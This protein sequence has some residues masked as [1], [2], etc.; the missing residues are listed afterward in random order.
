MTSPQQTKAQLLAQLEVLRQRVAELEAADSER[1]QAEAALQVSETRYRRLFETA[2]DGILILE[3][4]T[5]Q[6]TDVNPFLQEMLG[7]A[8]EE[9]LGKQLWEIGPFKDALASQV[10]FAELQSKGYIRYE[11]L[12]LERSDGRH[13][14]VE[15]VSNVYLVD[16]QRVIQCNIRD[17]TERKQHEREIESVAAVGAAL[18]NAPTRGE[19]LPVIVY[20]VMQLL[21][22]DGAA[23]LMRDPGTGQSVV[24]LAGGRWTSLTG[25]RLPPGQG[26]VGYVVATGQT[27]PR[28]AQPDLLQALQ[29]VASVPL[30]EQGQTI[31]ALWIGRQTDLNS[32]ELRLL[33]VI[34]EIAANALSRAKLLETLE[35]RVTERTRELAA[36]NE[37]LQELDR[38]KD[39]FISTINH[40]LRTP[41]ANVKLYINLFERGR[42]EKH[43]LYLQ[44]LHRE[45]ARLEKI[46]EDLLDFSRLDQ[47]LTRVEPAP[48]HVD[49]IL[50]WLITDR[51]AVAAEHGLTLMY[52]PSPNS[53][54]ALANPA[55]LSQVISNLLNN[56]FHYTPAGGTVTVTCAVAQEHARDWVV[57]S[58][59]DTGPGISAIDLPHLFER[60]YRGEIAQKSNAPGTGLGLTISKEIVERLGGQITV[61][62]QPGHGAVFN[63][64]LLLVH[65]P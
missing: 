54:T 47:T 18:R 38:L 43:D 5:G 42:P 56:A 11:S 19:M 27:D 23:L 55:L 61:D 31:G 9:F 4:D 21:R 44:T 45:V 53:L 15:F 36:A 1:Q 28:I 12:P 20:Q 50:S 29:A 41:F 60:F 48:I 2:Q 13:M 37:H 46:I 64:W 33:H 10:A 63:V 35:D 6:I 32:A 7:H 8:R 49:Q 3:A 17:I 59:R 16:G 40:E 34:C 58:V 65:A 51:S 52:E 24:V 39:E 25:T 26:V 30:I 57:I 14:D 22:A 62:S